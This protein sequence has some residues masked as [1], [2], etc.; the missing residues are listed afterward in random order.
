MS[1][2][3]RIHRLGTGV[4]TIMVLAW[5]SCTAWAR[6]LMLP[7]EGR[8]VGVAWEMLR[9]GDWLTPTLNGLPYF[10]KPPLFYWITASSLGLLGHHEF[11]ARVAPILGATL[12]AMTLFLFVRR[13][14][15]ERT[16]RATLVALLAQP[17]WLIGSQ[18][19]NLD[20]LV[21]GCITATIVLLAHA[22]LSAEQGGP[23]RGALAG[24]YA[25]AACGIL[26][27][28]LIGFVLPALAIFVWLVLARRWRLL[29]KLL[30]LPGI[31][32][33]LA[34]V[35]PWFVAMQQRFPDF[36]NYFFVVQQFDRFAAGGFNNPQ[37]FWFYL[38]VL[39]IFFLPWLPWLPR[40]FRERC[41]AD[42]AQQAVR[43][44]MLV[45]PASVVLFF[46]IPQSKLLGYVLPAVPPLTFLVAQGY[47]LRSSGSRKSRRLWALSA[48]VPVALAA[49]L[50]A[51]LA[52]FPVRSMRDFGDVLDAQRRAGEPIYMLDRYYFD[53]P[54]YAN[55]QAP[56]A[57]VD[58]WD[59]PALRRRDSA[60]KELADAGNFDSDAAAEFL[61]KTSELTARLC[62]AP[63]AWVI[64]PTSSTGHFAFLRGAPALDA[65]DDT[66]L[67]RVDTKLRATRRALG[68]R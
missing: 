60:P 43:L 30:W 25:S 3:I 66:T 33:F 6:A 22:A 10:H 24:A 1:P 52:V 41:R 56:V 37:P 18:F 62:A 11:A 38:A 12:G 21:A 57:V 42:S 46:S 44:L 50:I 54:F 63:V 45:W 59:D 51:W 55:L 31:A 26:A 4:T 67:W 15:D 14:A 64:G 49:G 5:F 29:F 13:W 36:L 2:A 9:S 35:L 68:C 27:K 47:L 8:Y 23:Y 40:L 32:L 19:A 39:A 53:L 34:L 7:D 48:A 65:R 61:V 58:D 17:L 16:A 20:M 28:G